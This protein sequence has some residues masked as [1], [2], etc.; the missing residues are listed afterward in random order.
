MFVAP[1]WY[2]VDSCIPEGNRVASCAKYRRVAYQVWSCY[3]CYGSL[4]VN[5]LGICSPIVNNC[6]N[7]AA[8]GFCTS[9]KPDYEL[10]GNI[11]VEKGVKTQSIPVKPDEA[12]EGCLMSVELGKCPKCKQGHVLVDKVCL[13]IEKNAEKIDNALGKCLEG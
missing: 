13:S 6:L 1:S 8:I 5:G 3:S 7:Y 2:N 4:R 11:C 12:D 10:S 9:C